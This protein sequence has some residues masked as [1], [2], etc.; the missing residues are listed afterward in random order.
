M[1]V[2][3][4]HRISRNH[5]FSLVFSGCDLAIFRSICWMNTIIRT[6][7]QRPSWAQ[8]LPDPDTIGVCP[9]P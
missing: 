1:A 8:P 4:I 2:V 5:W 9:S 7:W 6:R 3:K